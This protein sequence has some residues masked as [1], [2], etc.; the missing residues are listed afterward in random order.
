MGIL[1]VSRSVRI[2]QSGTT[3]VK[4]VHGGLR[5]IVCFQKRRYEDWKYSLLLIK[6]K[7]WFVLELLISVLGQKETQRTPLGLRHP[8]WISLQESWVTLTVGK[9][10]IDFLIDTTP[11]TFP[12]YLRRLVSITQRKQS[13]PRKTFLYLWDAKVVSGLLRNAHL[14]YLF[15]KCRFWKRVK[16][17][18]RNWL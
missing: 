6:G 15:L 9:K 14:R 18:F 4:A 7:K 13:H 10:L 2:F 1:H 5:K 8:V 16:K 11:Q 3:N 12:A 17:Q